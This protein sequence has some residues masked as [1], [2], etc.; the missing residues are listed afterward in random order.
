MVELILYISLAT[1][2]LTAAV[3]FSWD[4]IYGREKSIRQ[5]VVQQVVRA[6][7]TRIGYEITRA[8]SI[9][10]ISVGELVIV[11]DTGSTTV[12]GLADGRVFINFSGAGAINL[13]SNQTK[14]DELTF[15][16]FGGDANSKNIGV[17]LKIT[18]A[19]AAAKGELT[20]ETFLQASFE[21]K[22]QFNQARGLLIDTSLAN[23]SGTSLLG[24]TLQNQSPSE[25]VIDRMS[26]S[27]TG[28]NASEH[29]TS[30]N[31]G[32][33]TPEFSGSAESD[34]TIDLTDFI[35]VG[36]DI[37]NLDNI[38]FDADVTGET[39]LFYFVMADGSNARA[40]ILLSSLA[41]PSPT[42]TPTP[43][44]TPVPTPTLPGSSCAFICQS[45]GFIDGTCR[46]NAQACSASGETYVSAGDTFCTGGPNA[47][48]CC[49]LP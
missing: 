7:V 32:G 18:Q 47:D 36:S 38:T 17:S 33:G 35:L 21:L 44:P 29:V 37:V 45:N 14:V 25:V 28:S 41:S 11:D 5:Q 31:I 49:C 48:T 26:V 39:L 8:S 20:A 30:V 16:D 10:S 3:A 9:Q 42:L 13:T 12:I 43:T 34:T 22:G 19:G 40:K 27:W 15:S 23:F 24:V 2:F 4:V 46:R 1:L 6:A